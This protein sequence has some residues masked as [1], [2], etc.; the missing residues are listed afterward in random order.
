MVQADLGCGVEEEVRGFRHGLQEPGD[1]PAGV[2]E[3]RGD[4]VALGGD[5][6]AV[7]EGLGGR[8][9]ELGLGR[10]VA[11]AVELDDVA[12]GG[13][14]QFPVV[15]VEFVGDREDADREAGGAGEPVFRAESDR[16]GGGMHAVGADHQVEGA[17][18]G[19]LEGDHHAVVVLDQ[20]GDRIA[21]DVFDILRGG[22]VENG[23][24]IP[25]QH[26]LVGG[27]AQAD[28]IRAQGGQP[29]SAAIDPFAAAHGGGGGPDL[30]EQTHALDD[31]HCDASNVDL[32]AARP[33]GAG[34]LDDGD[35]EAVPVQPIRQRGT[36]DAGAGDQ[37][38]LVR[39]TRNR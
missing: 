12:G 17:G 4:G 5:V 25:A 31:F 21:E 26:L 9:D 29:F 22:V 19:V 11:G 16:T 37:D 30:V 28:E 39:V 15:E 35:G 36:G 27:G 1:F 10:R 20:V 14:D 3:G 24:Q 32:V 33:Q 38:G 18:R 2:G 8:E 34:L 7:G 23:G 6:V 13:M